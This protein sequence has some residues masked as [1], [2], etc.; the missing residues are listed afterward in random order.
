MQVILPMTRH[1]YYSHGHGLWR[2]PS[3]LLLIITNEVPVCSSKYMQLASA[4]IWSSPLSCVMKCCDELRVSM[5]HYPDGN[6]KAVQTRTYSRL[7]AALCHPSEDIIPD[8]EDPEYNRIRV[9][10]QALYGELP[11]F[12][13][14]QAV[15]KQILLSTY[16]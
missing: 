7:L 14:Q 5:T 9:G 13:T 12:A 1:L 2:C 6:W 8:L 3:H 15:N 11:G 16:S 4:Y 10:L